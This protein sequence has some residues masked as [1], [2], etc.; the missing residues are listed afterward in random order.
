MPTLR[1]S[2]VFIR[3]FLSDFESTGAI[4][5]SSRWAADALLEPLR[6][7]PRKPLNVLE[8]GPGSG[9]VTVRILEHLMPEDRLTICE[10]NPRLMKA[11]RA[12]LAEMPNY[13]RYQQQITFFEGPVQELPEDQVFDLIICAIP[14]LNLECSIVNDIFDKFRRLSSPQGC[15][16]YFEYMGIRSVSLVASPPKRRKRIQ[17]LDHYFRRLFTNSLYGRKRVWLNF[18]PINVYTLKL[19]AN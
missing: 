15:I 12:K 19:A 10:I 16:T 6:V 4:L 13:L 3:E 14:F 7:E 9:P 17:E 5:P 18:P 1:E 8:V 11:L 2:L